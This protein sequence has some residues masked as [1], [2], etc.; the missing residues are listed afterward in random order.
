MGGQR[1][2][3]GLA[4]LII[5]LLSSCNSEK[6]EESKETAEIPEEVDTVPP[7]IEYGFSLDSFRV[8]KDTVKEGWT[9]S[10]L[11][12]P[13]GISQLNINE[14]SQA[15]KDSTVGLNY[16]V[17]GKCFTILYPKEDSVKARYCIYEVNESEYVVFDFND[18]VTAYRKEKPYEL[19][20]REVSGVIEYSLWNAFIDNDLSPAMAARVANIFQW[21]INFF[22]VQKGDYF[23]IL[24]KE[25][26][27]EGKAIGYTDISAI[28]F[29]TLDTSYHALYFEYNDTLEGYW[30][31]NGNSLRRALLKAPLDYIRVTSGFSHSRMHP[32]LKRPTTHYGVDFGAP[33]G[34][35]VYSVGDGVITFAGWAGG[36]GN[37]IK[38]QHA[39][40]IETQ[41]MHLQG[42]APGITTGAR[43]K[44]GQKIGEVGSTGLSTGPHLDYRIYISGKPVD[45]LNADIP[46]SEPLPD[47][48]KGDFFPLRDSLVRRLEGI[49]VN[50][51]ADSGT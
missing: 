50:H 13:H 27:V 19:I 18:R 37:F 6:Q 46:T 5:F 31:K 21:S 9:L 51:S 45:P 26:Q 2:A 35:P 36:A 14:A 24:F 11:L 29:H 12:L 25:K 17:A 23:R 34:T 44:Q 7:R 10:H 15:S 48:I 22:A 43:V 32:I 39:N 41:Y 30:D 38:I 28:E 20:D 8:V 16:I 40:Q 47:S 42:Y 3:V 4:T 33:F 49:H 1:F